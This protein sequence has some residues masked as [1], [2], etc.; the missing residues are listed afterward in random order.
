MQGQMLFIF[1][2]PY[3]ICPLIF[4]DAVP[5][6]RQTLLKVQMS[7]CVWDDCQVSQNPGI[8]DHGK[9]VQG[10]LVKG[11]FMKASFQDAHILGCLLGVI[12]SLVVIY[13]IIRAWPGCQQ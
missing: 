6:S 5:L 9:N 8:D 4:C 1:P 13:S 10:Y 7:V 3:Y 11:Q 2:K 12:F